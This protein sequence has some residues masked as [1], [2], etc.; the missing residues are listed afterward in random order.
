MD[1]EELLAADLTRTSAY[2]KRRAGN[3]RKTTS[4]K[5]TTRGENDKD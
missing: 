2:K 3:K 5:E 4:N 1:I